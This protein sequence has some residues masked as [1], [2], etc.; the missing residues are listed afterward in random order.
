MT[1]LENFTA[2]GAIDASEKM[3]EEAISLLVREG[4]TPEEAGNIARNN[5]S[6]AN[7]NPNITITIEELTRV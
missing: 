1:G 3:I 6:R 4:H 2:K 7:G 5:F